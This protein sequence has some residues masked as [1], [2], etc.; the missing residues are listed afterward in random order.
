MIKIQ[1][2]CGFGIG[3]SMMLKITLDTIIK[4]NNLDV[5]VVCGD[6][7]SC[8][9]VDCDYIFISSSLADTIENRTSVPLV[10]IDNFV[11]KEY[12]L[13]KL[14]SILNKWEEEFYDWLY[15]R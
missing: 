13:E 2:V 7:S 8:L 12:L 1:T 6:I 11:D 5:E 15:W 9:S 4:E 3:S 14:K 10:L